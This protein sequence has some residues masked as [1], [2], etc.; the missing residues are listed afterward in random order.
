MNLDRSQRFVWLKLPDDRKARIA[1]A[2][3]FES[4]VL[5]ARGTGLEASRMS[6]CGRGNS[7]SVS[8]VEFL[9]SFWWNIR[10]VAQCG[11]GDLHYI[12]D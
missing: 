6:W 3:G 4:C 2:V 5:S 7:N 12:I 10:L 8:A 9:N 1:R 11:V